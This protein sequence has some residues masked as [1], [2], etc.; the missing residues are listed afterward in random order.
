MPVVFI[1]IMPVHNISVHRAASNYELIMGDSTSPASLPAVPLY[2][3]AQH[4]HVW[5]AGTRP[6]LSSGD[7]PYG[8]TAVVPQVWS[9]NLERAALAPGTPSE[10]RTWTEG[11]L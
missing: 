8:S 2:V 11:G 9:S 1:S 5:G 3:G 4:I 6:A 7:M 10:N